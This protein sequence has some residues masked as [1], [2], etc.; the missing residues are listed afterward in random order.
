M[1]RILRIIGLYKSNSFTPNDFQVSSVQLIL[2]KSFFF[3]QIN[4]LNES[5]IWNEKRTGK[6]Q[7]ETGH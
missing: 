3:S 4:S 6:A 2:K 7:N 1:A 5:I